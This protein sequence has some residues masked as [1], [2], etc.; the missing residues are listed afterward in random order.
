M[1][2]FKS[3]GVEDIS[4]AQVSQVSKE[5]DTEVSRFRGAPLSKSYPVVWIDALYEKIRDDEKVTSK[6]IMIAMAINSEGKKEILAIEP[7]DNESTDT[8]TVVFDNLKSRGL[9]QI[10]LLKS[11]LCAIFWPEC[12]YQPP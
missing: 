9:E 12:H 4:A 10:G 2:V 6:A 1:H 8:W 7:M 5:L 3:F 11:I